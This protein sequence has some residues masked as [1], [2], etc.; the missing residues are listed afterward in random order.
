[1][2]V[3]A[4]AFIVIGAGQIQEELLHRSGAGSGGPG[5]GVDINSFSKS[6]SSRL[7]SFNRLPLFRIQK[8]RIPFEYE[9]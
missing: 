3:F 2:C 9:N 5:K 4:F 8:H 6:F 1:M 7:V